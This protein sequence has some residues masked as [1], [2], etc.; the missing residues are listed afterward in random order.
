[1]KQTRKVP[2]PSKWRKVDGS[3]EC[4]TRV[5]HAFG[6]RWVAQSF[7]RASKLTIIE[8][9]NRLR[10]AGVPIPAYKNLGNYDAY[11]VA[12][13]RRIKDLQKNNVAVYLRNWCD[14]MAN[15]KLPPERVNKIL[16]GVATAIG[17]AHTENI[18]SKVAHD[19]LH[20][21]NAGNSLITTYRNT[22]Q[23]K[24]ALMR[25]RKRFFEKIVEQY[26]IPKAQKAEVLRG[27]IINYPDEI[28]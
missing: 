24:A 14:A 4:I 22:P 21:H 25:M 7:G 10:K 5:G 27:L 15:G 23:V 9:M 6:R 11:S 16:D 17:K 13:P 1:M 3:D 8:A 18:T 20:M 26:D 28:I 19:F 2:D 12:G